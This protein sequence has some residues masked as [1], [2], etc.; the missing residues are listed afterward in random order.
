MS[1]SKITSLVRQLAAQRLSPRI[2]KLELILVEACNL[3]CNYCF[4]FASEPG[5]SMSRETALQAVDLLFDAS[6]G[7]EWVGITFIG[8]EP[9]LRFDLICAVMERAENLAGNTEKRTCFDMNTN[10]VLLE[11]KHARF[12]SE[13]GLAYCLSLDGRQDDNDRHRKARNGDGAYAL[14][15]GKLRM[16][17][18][19][20]HWQGARVTVMPDTAARLAENVTSLHDELGINQFIIGFATSVPWSDAQITDYASGLME[21][22]EFY[23][24][25]RLAK[26]SRRLRISILDVGPI[27]EAYLARGG[28]DFG[29]GAGSG[30]IAVAP[31]GTL[32]GCTKLAFAAGRKDDYTLGT[33]KTGLSRPENRRKLLDHSAEFRPKCRYCEIAAFCT[34]GCYAANLTDTGDLYTPA[35]YYCKLMFAQKT[36][37]DYAR[38]RLATLGIK[39]L[40]WESELPPDCTQHRAS[41]PAEA[42]C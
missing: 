10:G 39:S 19:H 36:A 34:G 26:R 11:E 38:R 17:K 9:M 23:L 6:R 29:C 5:R 41:Q 7:S 24:E 14:I 31:D 25:E 8:G 16:L 4:E 40:R 27:S 42:C 21:T 35:D 22:F 37:A 18:R 32:H 3:R 2:V 15:A 33:V 28:C 30:R 1:S 20:Q 12:F 13:Q